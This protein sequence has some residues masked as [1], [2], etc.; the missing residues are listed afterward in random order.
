MTKPRAPLSV[1]A[2]LARIAG[3]IPGDYAEM[4]RLLGRSESLV[5]AWGDPQRRERVAIDDAIVLD[6][7]YRTAGGDGAP[8]YEAYGAKLSADGTLWFA[9]E[10]ALGRHAATLIRECGE[11]E[12][13]VVLAAQ[14]GATR[15]DRERAMREIEEAMAVL[16]RARIMLG[17]VSAPRPDPDPPSTGPPPAP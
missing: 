15:R 2:A 11:A 1:G 10:I 12:A 9:E 8:I 13:A 17:G 7:A 4:G 14:P 5:R 16:S 6:L 3:Y